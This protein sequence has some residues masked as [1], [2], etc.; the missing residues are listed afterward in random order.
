MARSLQSCI[1][2]A[3]VLGAIIVPAGRVL[4]QSLSDDL[5]ALLVYNRGDHNDP[6]ARITTALRRGDEATR[7][8]IITTLL[9]ALSG[10]GTADA[11]DHAV[12]LL[13]RYARE[14]DLP[15]L[16]ALLSQPGATDSA[17]YVLAALPYP[18]VD[19]ILVRALETVSGPRAVALLGALADRRALIAADAAAPFLSSDDATVQAAAVTALIAV[20]GETAWSHLADSYPTMPPVLQHRIDRA[21]LVYAMRMAEDLHD[22]DLRVQRQAQTLTLRTLD[23]DALNETIAAA[24]GQDDW[25]TVS[26]ATLSLHDVACPPCF[27]ALLNAGDRLPPAVRR[28]LYGALAAQRFSP[29]LP[30]LKQAYAS[31]D[32]ATRL[33]ALRATINWG[34]A[35]FILPLAKVI[36][37]RATDRQSVEPWLA[38][39]ALANLA[40]DDVDA[41]LLALVPD[42]PPTFQAPLLFALA[43]RNVTAALPELLTFARS[44]DPTLWREAFKGLARLAGPAHLDALLT[45]L[46]EETDP[47][48]RNQEVFTLHTILEQLPD[49]T[50]RLARLSSALEGPTTPDARKALYQLMGEVGGPQAVAALLTAFEREDDDGRTSVVRALATLPPDAVVD[51]LFALAETHA[52]SRAGQYA[53][54]GALQVLGRVAEDMAPETLLAYVK[55]AESLCSEPWEVKRL[56]S[57]VGAMGR[58]ESLPLVA[59][60]LKNP[61]VR[62]EAVRAVHDVVLDKAVV[63]A[64]DD[65]Q[66]QAV[67]VID[68]QVATGWSIAAAPGATAWIDLDLG[69][70]LQ[71]RAVTLDSTPSPQY[72]PPV[73]RVYH[74]TEPGNWGEAIAETPGAPLTEIPLKDTIAR[75]L[76]FEVPASDQQVIWVLH[77]IRFLSEED[78]ALGAF[79]LTTTE[80][81]P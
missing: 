78:T 63:T 80:G 28:W 17:S 72:V 81:N 6:R 34:D 18:K 66:A 45:L 24:L 14:T 44:D 8:P 15:A 38:R 70:P 58:A 1:T 3:I 74:A 16:D 25:D 49:T 46:L 61:A 10:N 36:S 53:L 65:A 9:D 60:Y 40:G 68:G 23:S 77:E 26:A 21:G 39:A 43:Q 76:R 13:S 20:G 42:Q 67:N 33:A 7:A 56:L 52:G 73:Y 57:A 12:R 47:R 31:V 32:E 22:P 35:S 62:Q 27:E 64:S 5:A 4:P 50:A 55:R 75:Y 11:H 41:Q 51:P 79:P 37:D 69:R 71:L 59:A 30:A 19:A 2:A 54:E 48:K 29:G